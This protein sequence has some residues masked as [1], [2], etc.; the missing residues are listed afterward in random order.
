M[1]DG[2]SFVGRLVQIIFTPKL[3]HVYNLGVCVTMVAFEYSKD[4]PLVTQKPMLHWAPSLRSAPLNIPSQ[5]AKEERDPFQD[6]ELSLNTQLSR[7]GL[8]F[9]IK[10]L[11]T[12]F[13][14]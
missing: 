3:L 6:W 7:S 9:L 4:T 14:F 5:Q 8:A 10:F 11:V 2:L 1:I 13:L 12:G